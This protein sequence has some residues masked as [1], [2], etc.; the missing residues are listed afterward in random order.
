MA[1]ALEAGILIFQFFSRLPPWWPA[2][3]LLVFFLVLA[4]RWRL[5]LL[6][7][8]AALAFLVADLEA[9]ALLQRVLPAGQSYTVTGRVEG[10]PQEA[11]GQ[12]RLHLAPER[13]Q[14]AGQ[15]LR[16]PPLIEV[17]GPM[18][19][20]PVTGQRWQIELRSEPLHS[21]RQSSFI[22]LPR[23][24][25][26]QGVLGAGKIV[27]ATPLPLS[28]FDPLD[29][30]A[31]WRMQVVQASNAAL[32]REWAGYLQ[33]LTVGIG[34]QL[35]PS[36]WQI[37]RD[38]GTAHLLVISGSHVAVVTGFFLWFWRALWRRIPA[39]VRRWPAQ[40]AA[41][42]AAIPV[43][44]IYAYLAGLQSPG[45]RA[46][47]M[48]SAASVA[49]LLGRR[50]A[51]WSG[52]AFSAAM[53]AL[54]DPGQVVDLGYWLSILA[55]AI[56]ISLGVEEGRWRQALAAQWRVSILLLPLL[57]YLFGNISLIS[58]LA[59]LLVIPLIELLAVPVALLGAAFAL[60]DMEQAY[61][62][63]FRLVALEMQGVTWVLDWLRHWPAA[64][65]TV[66]PGRLVA[67]LAASLAFSLLLLPRHWP[68]R[69]L[70]YLGFVPLL[71]PGASGDGGFR[72]EEL[73]VGK[74]MAIF[75]QDGGHTGLYTAN[76]WH[77]PDQRALGSQLAARLQK[78][79]SSRLDV[80]VLGDLSLPKPAPAAATTLL[81]SGN[82]LPE[83]G[84]P[85]ATCDGR[86]VPGGQSLQFAKLQPCA[87]GLDGG[88]VL[89]LGDMDDPT[90]AAFLRPADRGA[91][92]VIFAPYSWDPWQRHA[93]LHAYP[94]ASIRYVGE[95]GDPWRWSKGHLQLRDGGGGRPYWDLP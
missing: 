32:P 90:L 36:T 8:T 39:L 64:M 74:G 52:L 54:L 85:V 58:P 79:G 1:L 21:L 50:H 2:F 72:A 81:P 13:L 5:A 92:R 16:P 88:R 40:Q 9:N 12:W 82:R 95:G 55:V 67:A 65:L 59:N 62:L 60:L 53:M 14:A 29:L 42:L 45:E 91:P 15:R 6:P 10:I 41:L 51:V 73:A 26:W 86:K 84:R 33:A 69:K 76:L 49:A 66:T 93:L 61:R 20:V 35:S 75:W 27:A 47:W 44:W 19:E 23:S 17:H 89:L 71:A 38:T 87:L 78:A 24:R 83:L 37:Y 56:L 80:W 63:L 28:S 43:A 7:A 34:N 25:F 31:Q 18:P 48:I 94:Y 77:R 57:A 68:G 22:D 70:A 46:A 4:W 3:G 30:L 11:R